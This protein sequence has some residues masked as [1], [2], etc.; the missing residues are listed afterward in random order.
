MKVA[1]IRLCA[2]RRRGFSIL[3]MIGVLVMILI[4]VA[5]V[6][7]R[8]FEAIGDS[9]IKSATTTIK[10]LQSAV[11]KYFADIGTLYPLN[12]LGVA[13]PMANG[14]SNADYGASMPDVLTLPSSASPATTGTGLW[15]KFRGPYLDGFNTASS[16]IG[17]S[18]TVSSVA[19]VASITATVN[20]ANF[21]LSNNATTTIN[22]GSQLVFI[23]YSGVSQKEFEKLDALLDEGIGGTSA[24]KEAW[25]KV[26]WDPATGNLMVYIA[27]K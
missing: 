22:S 18:V 4:L 9:K 24:E 20:N 21:S 6:A 17:T 1:K 2:A 12:D 5:A 25:G 11:A 27:H 3:E 19:S 26:K 16:V 10:T 13:V 23:T 14:V 8:I 15:R 7:P